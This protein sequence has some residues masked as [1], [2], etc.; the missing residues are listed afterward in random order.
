MKL[1]KTQ[2]EKYFQNRGKE[3]EL[4][5]HYAIVQCDTSVS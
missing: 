3:A 2:A 1:G 4:K 5:S